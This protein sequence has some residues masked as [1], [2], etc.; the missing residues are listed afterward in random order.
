VVCTTRADGDFNADVVDPD[1]LRTRQRAVVD[2]PWTWLDEVHGTDVIVVER[3]GHGVGATADAAI[4]TALGAA[5]SVWVGDCAPVAFVSS[6]VVGVA[7]AGWRGLR[8]GVIA[9]T[10]EQMRAAGATSIE[11]RI[12]PHIHRCCYEF[13]PIDL[14]AI[15]ERFGTG[16]RALTRDGRPALDMAATLM[17]ALDE[18]EVPVVSVGPCTGCNGDRYWSHRA[19]AERGRQAMVVW[20]EEP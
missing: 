6:H 8:D 10:V 20:M 1:V 18:L 11:A 16:V 3:P 17:C 9:S 13:G 12:G 5:L 14:E 4:T 15:V 2:L 7:H 19:R